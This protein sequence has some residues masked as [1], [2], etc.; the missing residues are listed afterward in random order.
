MSKGDLTKLPIQFENAMKEILK[1]DYD[2]FIKSLSEPF[3]QGLRCNE[4][5][6]SPNKLQEISP[7]ELEPVKWTDNGFYYSN[8]FQPAKHPYYH[9]GLYY[10]QE[11][12]AMTPVS[13]FNIEPG[14]MVLDLCGAPGG[15]ST[16][17]GAKLNNTGLLVCNDISAS[18]AKAIVKNIEMFGIKNALV[19]SESPKKLE[20]CYEGFFDKILVDAPCSGEGMFRK[21]KSMI[22]S[23]EDR[24]TSYYEEIQREILPSAQKMLKG[25]GYMVY[26][27]CTFSLE[28][29]E[30]MIKWFLNKYPNFELVNIPIEHGFEEGREGLTQ[31]VRL[32]PHKL[33]GEGHFAALLRKREEEPLPKSRIMD[34]NN[35]LEKQLT[36]FLKFQEEVL[37]LEFDK[38]RLMLIEDK[39][40]YLPEFM[41]DIKRLRV[42]RSGWL[43]GEIKKN[44][45]EP[46]QAFASAL[47][48]DEVKNK[49]I[50]DVEDIRLIK[51][52]KGETIILEANNTSNR[53]G[54]LIDSKVD[55]GYYLVC[56][57]DYPL[58]WV[59]KTGNILKNKYSV[60]WRWQ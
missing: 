50:F 15:K 58:G 8:D 21:D 14:D 32:W 48:K 6:L 18:R 54:E 5:K 51:Y 34:Y 29:N 35:L 37:N 39:L 55:D 57:N 33:E 17:L 44:R 47:K 45:F 28:E 42:L 40:Y 23:F 10:I 49:I 19:L 56:V 38:N 9:A 60:G 46:S 12:S 59:K 52:L 2:S 22:K 11:P 31:T 26:S 41:P 20:S 7:Y 13:I 4:M 3:Y 25:G 36:D 24:G 16:Q 1:D 43:L 30:N 27:T 53:T